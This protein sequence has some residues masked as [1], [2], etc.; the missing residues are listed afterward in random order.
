M[1]ENK[2]EGKLE[3]EIENLLEEMN[4]NIKE[5][6]EKGGEEENTLKKDLDGL[7]GVLEENEEH[8]D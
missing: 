8:E 3:E 5:K 7:A 4:E 1:A 2:E 6:V